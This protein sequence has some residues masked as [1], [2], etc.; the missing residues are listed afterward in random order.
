VAFEFE[1]EVPVPV[2]VL[3]VEDAPLLSTLI[4]ITPPFPYRPPPQQFRQVR[5]A[6]IRERTPAI[7]PAIVAISDGLLSESPPPGVFDELV[8]VEEEVNKPSVVP[9]PVMSNGSMDRSVGKVPV[10]D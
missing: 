7:V 8:P 6:I 1:V 2:P 4:L 9:I 5:K 3:P 10:L